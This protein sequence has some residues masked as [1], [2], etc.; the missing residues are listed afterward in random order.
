MDT[1]TFMNQEQP[2]NRWVIVKVFVV[3]IFAGCLLGVSVALIG[4]AV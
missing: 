1:R 4:I 3:G 2:V